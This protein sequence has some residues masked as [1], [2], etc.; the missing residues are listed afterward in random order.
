MS[1]RRSL[2]PREAVDPVIAM[3]TWGSSSSA[4]FAVAPS[5]DHNVQPTDQRLDR[6]NRVFR[7]LVGDLKPL[8]DDAVT[9]LGMRVVIAPGGARSGWPLAGERLKQRGT[10]TVPKGWRPR[11]YALRNR[12]WHHV[13]HEIAQGAFQVDLE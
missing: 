11:R 13:S 9:A 2:L 4:A 10:R 3:A 8:V 7:F 12:S 1:R 5:A 6:L